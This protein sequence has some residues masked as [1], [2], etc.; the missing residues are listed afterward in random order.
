MTNAWQLTGYAIFHFQE[1]E[2][3]EEGMGAEEEPLC[4]DDDVSEEESQNDLFDTDNVI[5]C[6]YDKVSSNSLVAYISMA[7]N[8]HEF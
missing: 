3:E 5:V 1:N 4:S 6:L 7:T 2:E 8:M